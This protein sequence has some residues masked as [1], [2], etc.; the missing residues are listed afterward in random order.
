[1]FQR[2]CQCALYPDIQAIFDRNDLSF[3]GY[4]FR[5][6]YVTKTGEIFD[7]NLMSLKNI[8]ISRNYN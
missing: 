4:C 5:N 2:F 3:Y 8:D 7:K 6:I 1:M